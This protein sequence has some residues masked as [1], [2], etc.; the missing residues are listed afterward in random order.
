MIFS[1]GQTPETVGPEMLRR[2]SSRLAGVYAVPLGAAVP[3]RDLSIAGVDAPPE[4]FLDDVVPVTV[5]V[6][7]T[8]GDEAERSLDGVRIRLVDPRETDPETGEARVLDEQA[9]D[10][11]APGEVIRLSAPASTVGE[12]PWRVEVLDAPGD[13]GELLTS[14]NVADIETRVIDRALRVLYVEA[15]PRWEFRYLKNLLIREE[16]V[17]VS[18]ML[19]SADQD[20]AQEGNRPIARLPL[21]R[22]EFEAYDVVI[23]GDVSV[24]SLGFDRLEQ[25]QRLVAERGAGLVWIGGMAAVPR[26]YT[27]TTMA[28]L[29]P[30]RDPAAVSEVALPPG[31]ASVN[32]AELAE[33]LSVMQIRDAGG[34]PLEIAE[35]AELQWLQEVGPLKP[36]AEVLAFAQPASAGARS[37]S[38]ETID[39]GSEAA[40]PVVVRM[41]FGAGQVLYLA[42][43]ETWRWRYGR[44]SVVFEQFWIQLIRLLTRGQMDPSEAATSLSVSH[45]LVDLGQSV[46]LEAVSRDPALIAR[47]EQTVEAVV[48]DADDPQRELARVTLRRETDSSE[49]SR[50]GRVRYRAVWEP[51]EAGSFAIR[52]DESPMASAATSPSVRVR[53][54]DAEARNP[55]TDH[56]KLA[57][58]AEATGGAVVPPAELGR[59]A[60]LIPS[61][62]RRTPFEIRESLWDSWLALIMVLSFLTLEWTGRKLI[63][64]V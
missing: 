50:T 9:L 16:S 15:Y 44:G 55:E 36:A 4:A 45:R 19:L 64:L 18:T 30:M 40:W 2:L 35:L 28:S 25:L 27:G 14:N 48:V 17:E 60:E 37:E 42:T 24:D 57:S 20:F 54:T 29:L 23:L 39:G 8:G 58:L 10:G 12:L 41:R 1:D 47:D 22:E 21:T 38:P 51:T 11:V 13:R 53:P 63:R 33:S 34:E 61:R 32:A 5:S 49:A 43:D 52:L 56:A 59:L 46:V 6:D 62:P 7:V 26:E 31:G 3:P